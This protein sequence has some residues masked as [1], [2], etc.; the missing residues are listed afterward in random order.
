MSASTPEGDGQARSM[1]LRMLRGLL[2]DVGLPIITYYLLHLLSATDWVALLAA[3]GVAGVRLLWGIVAKR[4]INQ[5]AIVMLLIYGVGL[6]LASATGDP[7]ALLMK[8]SL[9]TGSVGLVFLASAIHGSRPLTLSAMQSF[10][11][12]RADQLAEEYRTEPVAHRG[13]LLSAY[14]W[15]IGLLAEAILRIPVVYLL[16]IDIGYGVSEAMLVVAFVVLGGWNVWY[17]RRV[18]RVMDA[19]SASPADPST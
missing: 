9:I 2:V 17:M 16:P 5:F 8:S 11:P 14:V 13:Y 6:A 7:R 15:G 10:M 19:A 3:T 12:G 18:R 1:G 4:E